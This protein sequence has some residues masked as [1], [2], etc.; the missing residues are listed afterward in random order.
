M[1]RPSLAERNKLVI[2]G[3]K[4]KEKKT[5]IYNNVRESDEEKLYFG[6][7]ISIKKK[8]ENMHFHEFWGK[9]LHCFI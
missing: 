8:T 1:K 7:A 2:S 6:M 4:K 9:L 3:K 5:M